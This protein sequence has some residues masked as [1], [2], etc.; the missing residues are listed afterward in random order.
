MPKDKSFALDEFVSMQEHHVKERTIML[1]AKNTE[2]ENAVEDLFKAIS[3]FT[4]DAR[5]TSASPSKAGSHHYSASDLRPSTVVAGSTRRRRDT[6]AWPAKEME[7]EVRRLRKHY[8]TL[9]YRAI[10]SATKNSLNALKK[11]ICSRSGTGFLF[12]ERPFFEVDVRLAVPSVRLRCD[13]MFA[14]V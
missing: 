12:L 6:Y 10:L 7:P 2:V 5:P 11:R 3:N 14:H 8:N 9:L 1:A 4:V 13:A